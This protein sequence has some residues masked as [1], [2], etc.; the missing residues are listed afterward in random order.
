MASGPVT[1]DMRPDPISLIGQ[2]RDRHDSR[3]VGLQHARHYFA[4]AVAFVGPIAVALLVT[5]VLLSDGGSRAHLSR[6]AGAALILTECLLLLL[7]LVIGFLGVGGS[8]KHWIRERLRAELLRREEFLLL[9]RVGPYLNATEEDTANRVCERLVSI[10]SDV[11]DPLDLIAMAEGEQSWRDALEDARAADDLALIPN[12]EEVARN[13][14]ECRIASQV[15]YF[16]R[17]SVS[18][19]KTSSMLEGA[20]K[21]ILIFALVAS[22]IHL[23]SVSL[24][25]ELTG[26]WELAL[27]L[28]LIPA[29]TF[30]AFGALF[31]HLEAIFGS[32][33]LSRSYLYHAQVLEEVEMRLRRLEPHMASRA[34]GHRDAQFQMRRIVLDVEEL[35]SN[36]L[37]I[38]WLLMYPNLPKASA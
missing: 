33:R 17:K 6:S 24:P 38:W 22:L 21:L 3:A 25:G 12:A 23:L 35:L 11:N 15:K 26:S 5:H 30:P 10:D 9:A 14:I 36:E 13:Y 16:S 7:A 34:P 1:A 4:L 37:R 27:R 18:H 2:A 31:E 8:H 32:E 28:L 19:H 29:I 20:T